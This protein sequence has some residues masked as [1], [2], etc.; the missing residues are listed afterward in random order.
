MKD[1]IDLGFIGAGNLARHAILGLTDSYDI[2][3][4]DPVQ[5]Q[6]IINLG[7][8]YLSIEQLCKNS[9]VIF[10]TIK[11]NISEGILSQISDYIDDKLVISFIAGKSLKILEKTLSSKNIIRAMP[12]LGISNGLSPIAICS[13]QG[14]KVSSGEKIL[15]KLGRC[16]K[17]EESKFDAFTSIFGAGPA[18]ISYIA[19]LLSEIAS[20]NGFENSESLIGDVIGGTYEIHNSKNKPSFEKIKSMVASKGGVTE[21]ALKKIE[22][23]GMDKV[24]KAAI[25]DA[26]EKSKKLAEN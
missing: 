1:K 17:I 11:P 9:D 5:N 22:S 16:L 12:S 15:N 23:S 14:V 24:W 2:K 26:I 6:E 8:T 18:Y 21:A 20:E 4:S 3:V 19:K 25:E 7:I 10:L 13:N